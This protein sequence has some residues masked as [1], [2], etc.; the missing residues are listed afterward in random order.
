[1]LVAH[2]QGEDNELYPALKRVATAKPEVKALVDRFQT[3]MTA[4]TTVALD[5]FEKYEGGG[6]GLEFAPAL[7]KLLSALSARI[8]KEG[9]VLYRRTARSSVPANV[10]RPPQSSTGIVTG[11]PAP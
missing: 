8:R 1:M 11:S 10:R 7:G 2:L 3:E 5:F 4:I 9:A 6:N